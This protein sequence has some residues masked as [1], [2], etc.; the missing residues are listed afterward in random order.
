MVI[1]CHLKDGFLNEVPKNIPHTVGQLDL[2][3]NAIRELHNDSFEN[4]W[5][6]E[7]I[8]LTLNDIDIIPVA[9]FISVPNLKEIALVDN[10][11]E[12]NDDCFPV[13]LFHHTS[14]LKSVSIQSLYTMPNKLSL[15]NLETMIKK[16]PDTLE[17]LNINVPASD[18]FAVKFANFTKLKKLGIYDLNHLTKFNTIANDTFKP[19]ENSTIKELRIRAQNLHAV[20][21]LAFSHFSQLT[22]LD[23]SE[24]IGMSVADFSPASIGLQQTQLRKLVLESMCKDSSM[25]P[26]SLNDTFFKEFHLPHLADLH[27]GSAQITTII[28]TQPNFTGL[29]KLEILN[30]SRNYMSRADLF[31]LCDKY[32]KHL[33]SLRELDISHQIGMTLGDMQHA[34]F[35]LPP[36]LAIL[37]MSNIRHEYINIPFKMFIRN[38]SKLQYFKF[39][40]NYIDNL[41]IFDVQEPDPRVKLVADFLEMAWLIFPGHLIRASWEADY[42]SVV[43][44]YM[45]TNLAMNWETRVPSFSSISRTW[46]V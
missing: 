18:G 20:E 16:L 36:N 2:S 21:P 28:F 46:S 5:Y 4:C 11:L 19:L 9:I 14:D 35:S 3:N 42:E 40:E 12:Y 26:T 13:N 17:E 33:S 15:E 45:I 27:I 24:T 30:L 38:P 37:D 7:K 44:C 43:S 10:L 22:T 1:K 39:Q 32:L 8:D 23:M 41:L 29:P 31:L 34:Q 25:T 6:L